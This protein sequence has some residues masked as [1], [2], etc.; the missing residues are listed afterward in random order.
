[1]GTELVAYSAMLAVAWQTRSV[2]SLAIGGIA[3]GLLRALLSHWVLPGH[4]HRLAWNREILGEVLRFGRWIGLSTLVTFLAGQSDRLALGLLAPL[5]AVGVYSIASGLAL[6]PREVAGRMADSVILPF[7]SRSLRD[8]PHAL[9]AA[10]RRIRALFL[11]IG[12]LISASIA[13]LAPLFFELLYDDRYQEAVQLAPLIVLLGW[14]GAS[15]IPLQRALLAL[16]SSRP[17]AAWSSARA[18]VGLAASV[19]LYEFLG[20]AGFV[21]GQCL[22]AFVAAGVL[23]LAASRHGLALWRQ[24]LLYGL[25]LAGIV[26]ASI[27]SQELLIE[28]MLPDLSE[29]IVLFA[30]FGVLTL[31]AAWT[32]RR[33]AQVAR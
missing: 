32:L 3:H 30:P 8:D 1:M 16:G 31:V 5:S 17:I 26:S 7:L 33:V 13:I 24:D 18:V 27:A 11:P 15:Q 14:I 2:W 9:S 19:A 25:C 29:P 21:L 28:E 22:G 10:L 20:L 4:R 6:L 12:L 23:H